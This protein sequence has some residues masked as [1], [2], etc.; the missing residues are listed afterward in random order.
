MDRTVSVGAASGSLSAILLRLLS[1]FSA[2]P[3]IAACPLCPECPDISLWLPES[4]DPISLAFG[5]LIGLLLGPIFDFVHLVRQSWRVWLSTR[6]RD[7]ARKNPEELY[8]LA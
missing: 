5:I 8:R 6:L 1:D 4:I 7:L 3:G 2:D